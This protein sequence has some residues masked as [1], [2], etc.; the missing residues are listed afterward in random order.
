MKIRQGWVSNSSSSSFAILG[1]CFDM[2]GSDYDAIMKNGSTDMTMMESWE[3]FEFIE[4][5]ILGNNDE[6]KSCCSIDL[7]LVGNF[8]SE[9]DEF[10]IGV[11]VENLPMDRTLGDIKEEIVRALKILGVKNPRVGFHVEEIGN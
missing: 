8:N 7:E 11:Q 6:I 2:S 10:Y 5:D 4:E 9:C 1:A 3:Q